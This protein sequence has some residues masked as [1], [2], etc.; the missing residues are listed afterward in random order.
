MSGF[1]AVAGFTLALNAQGATEQCPAVAQITQ[2]QVAG[3][4]G[5]VYQAPGG[6]RFY[7]PTAVAADLERFH[8][9]RARLWKDSVMC[10]YVTGSS[11]GARLTRPGKR[12]AAEGEW[13]GEQCFP[14]RQGPGECRFK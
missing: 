7:N 10:D 3:Q 14:L 9:S 4:P 11:G 13:V 12:S 1:M 6:W 8:F 5:L 2:T